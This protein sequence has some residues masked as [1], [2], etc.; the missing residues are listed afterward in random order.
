MFPAANYREGV[1][2]QVRLSRTSSCS[3][4]RRRRSEMPLSPGGPDFVLNAISTQVRFDRVT[5]AGAEIAMNTGPFDQTR[6]D[7]EADNADR[8]SRIRSACMFTAESQKGHARYTYELLSALAIRGQDEQFKLI[9]V[10]SEN[11]ADL[12]RTSLYEIL[13]LLP[14]LKEREQ[15]RNK[16]EW[17]FSRLTHYVRRERKFLRWLWSRPDID[18]V[19]FQEYTPFLAPWHF[20]RIRK[21]GLAVVATV[22]NITNSGHLSRAYVRR[23]QGCWRS[24]W[25]SC[26]ALVVHT[27]GLRASLSEFLGPGHPPIRVTPHAVWD[28]RSAPP[29]PVNPPA[30]GDPARLLF[31]GM[32][33]PNK[34]LHVL[35][36]A[37]EF[38]PDC[39]LT[40]AGEPE[41]PAYFEE[42]R[43]L[44]TKLPTGRVEMVNR[45][46]DVSE[47]AGLFDR[48]HLVVLPY[49]EFSSQSGVLHQALAHGRPVLATDLGGMA[50]SVRAWGVG[51]L[52]AP[53]NPRALAEGILKVLQP[54][55]FREAAA[56][57][58]RVRE[59]LTWDSMAEATLD[60]YRA[61]LC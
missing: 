31:F 49:V 23:T 14:M 30:P 40:V 18:L 34:G 39:L 53:D 46:V 52:V 59:E 37:M 17:A 48:S 6:V 24:A 13:T 50:E 58:L 57:T 55:T 11:L 54:E 33:R 22:H 8:L 41:S 28:E 61:V 42:I 45:F 36:R 26:S 21:R 44:I 3:A 32:I 19:H 35:I 38:L 20:R 51:G 27:E 56:A 9:L 7:T 12:Y 2:F 43:A 15:F 25:R 5:I 47:I 29:S 4:I 10:T 60:V 1:V 16:V